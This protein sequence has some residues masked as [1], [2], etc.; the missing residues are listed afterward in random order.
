MLP[1]L[2]LFKDSLRFSHC[3]PAQQAISKMEKLTYASFI[4]MAPRIAQNVNLTKKFEILSSL[5]TENAAENLQKCHRNSSSKWHISRCDVRGQ[6]PVH[7]KWKCHRGEEWIFYTCNQ[8]E[9]LNNHSWKKNKLN[10]QTQ[11]LLDAIMCFTPFLGNTY[12]L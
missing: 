6:G 3:F 11:G 1:L 9:K 2:A 4:S 10:K 12:K 7:F 8:R 5:K